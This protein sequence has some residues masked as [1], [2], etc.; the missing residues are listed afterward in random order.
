MQKALDQWLQK[1]WTPTVE[2]DSTIQKKYMQEKIIK[3]DK[4]EEKVFIE[5]KSRNFTLQEYVDKISV[6]MQAKPSDYNSSNTHKLEQ[7]PVIGK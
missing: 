1:E 5:K 2:K 6:Y 4:G 7:L 3:K